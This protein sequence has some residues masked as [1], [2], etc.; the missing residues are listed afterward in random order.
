[1]I[2]KRKYIYIITAIIVALGTMV[3]CHENIIDET[4]NDTDDP[5][6]NFSYARINTDVSNPEIFSALTKQGDTITYYGGKNQDGTA[7]NI[8]TIEYSTVDGINN[9]I[10]FDDNGRLISIINNAG[11]TI[12]FEWQSQTS[13]II[14]AHSQKDNVFISTLVDFTGNESDNVPTAKSIQ[15]KSTHRTKPLTVDFIKNGGYEYSNFKTRTSYDPDNFPASQEVHLWI[16]QC[17]SNYD[18]KNYLILKNANNGITIGKLVN[19]ERIYK[20]SYIYQLPLSSYPSSATNQ[21]LCAN[22]DAVLRTM[23]EWL[24]GALVDSAPIV[25][26]INAAAFM[27]GVGTV[28]AVITDAIVF[29]LTAANCGISIFNSYGGVAGM[30]MRINSEWYYKEYIISDLDIIPVGYTQSTT[31]VGEKHRVNPTEGNIFITLEMPGEPV[32]N[33]FVLN[34]SNPGEGVD[35]TAT[36]EYSCIPENSTITLSIEGTDGYSDSITEN[37]SGSGSAVLHVPGAESGVYDLCTVTI[38]MP[39]GETLTMQA[40]LVFGN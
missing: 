37:I 27:T 16:H 35:Y 13:A 23:D 9:L 30:M 6:S 12:E 2:M 24:S 19:Y 1:M 10:D 39:F 32:I 14:K 29:A 26:A 38:N 15:Y 25:A 31:V 34:P 22:I 21:E 3:S 11:A 7:L 5:N 4:T 28:P 20:G 8:K 36:A 17:G 18:A 33:S 40:S